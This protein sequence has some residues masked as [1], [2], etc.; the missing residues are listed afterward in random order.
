MNLVVHDWGSALGF[1]WA[2]QNR[3]RVK[4]VSFMEALVGQ[5]NRNEF[6]EVAREAFKAFRSPLGK[7]SSYLIFLHVR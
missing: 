4:S 6:P 3:E 1:H 2:N 7:A 5:I